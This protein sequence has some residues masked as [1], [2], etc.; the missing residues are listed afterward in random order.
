MHRI[1][2]VSFGHGNVTRDILLSFLAPNEGEQRREEHKGEHKVV[3]RCAS[4]SKCVD[5]KKTN[6]T[7]EREEEE[8]EEEQEEE[9]EEKKGKGEG[10][11]RERKMR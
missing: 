10:R 7:N 8:K 11:G 4:A 2:A 5:A 9:E 3:V 1:Q 6:V